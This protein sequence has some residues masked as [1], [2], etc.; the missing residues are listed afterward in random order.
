MDRK[1][2]ILFVSGDIGGAKVQ[3]PVYKKLGDVDISVVTDA[4]PTGKAGMVWEKACIP[5]T[6]MLPSAEFEDVVRE[7]DLVFVGSCATTYAAEKF[8]VDCANRNQIFSV[9]GSDMWPNHWRDANPD[10]WLAIDEVHQKDILSR[11]PNWNKERVP[12]LG[13]PSFDYLVKL[14]ENRDSV[15]REMRASLGLSENEKVLLFWSLGDHRE[16]C[17]D[18]VVALLSTLGNRW[19]R[20]LVLIPRLHPKLKKVVSKEYFEFLHEMIAS[21]ATIHGVRVVR[22]DSANPEQLGLAADLV[23]TPWGTEGIKSAI[24][25]VP[26]VNTLLESHRFAMENEMEQP[27]PYLPTVGCGIAQLATEIA[28]IPR[29]IDTAIKSSKNLNHPMMP[30]GD[31]AKRT[32]EFLINLVF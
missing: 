11:R 14:M 17:N 13:Q 10:F 5:H 32:A 7:A 31:S 18:A 20:N 2:R 28:D 21:H 23:M 1:P 24:M 29:S 26:T 15:R 6:P 9:V 27:F 19:A 25:G 22:A 4:S 8:A 12:V 16:R 3:L 30:R